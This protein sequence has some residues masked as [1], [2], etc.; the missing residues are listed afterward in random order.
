MVLLLQATI[1]VA[2][3]TVVGRAWLLARHRKNRGFDDL[4]AGDRHAADLPP[5]AAVGWPP[6]G[7]LF[8]A[9]VDEGL[10]AMDTYLSEGAN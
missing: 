5:A 3:L 8:Q 7:T 9:Y 4:L 2:Y 1:T 6:E 10:G